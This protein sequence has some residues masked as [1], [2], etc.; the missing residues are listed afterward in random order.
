MRTCDETKFST[1]FEHTC[2]CIDK[3]LMFI[4]P[5]PITFS[6]LSVVD[7]RLSLHVFHIKPFICLFLLFRFCTVFLSGTLCCFEFFMFLL[8]A[9]FVLLMMLFIVRDTIF[10]VLFLHVKLADVGL[11]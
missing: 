2:V 5:L 11:L 10:V 3:L 6:S 1:R 4:T 7:L 8:F 9:F